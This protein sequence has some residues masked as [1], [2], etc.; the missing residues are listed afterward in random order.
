MEIFIFLMNYVIH[1]DDN[2]VELIKNYGNLVY[3]ILFII[4]FAE[5]GL[6]V[7]PVLPGDSLLFVLG[8]LSASGELNV[9]FISILLFVSAVLGDAINYSIGKFIGPKVFTD[10]HKR[11]FK[12]EHLMKAHEFYEKY[13]GKTI[14]L[15]RFI[16][17]IRTFAPFVAGVGIMSYRKF[18]L[19]NVI[20]AALWVSI[21]VAAGYFFGNIPVVKE[22][23]TLV[24]LAIIFISV[25]PMAFELLGGYLKKNKIETGK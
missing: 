12:K 23:F 14:I 22:N 9:C 20:G 21:C 6:V 24:V 3:P 25:L 19:Y 4:I 5:T 1:L 18:F 7:T 17:I 8:A 2:L 13:G 16:P 11:F 10:G 15:A